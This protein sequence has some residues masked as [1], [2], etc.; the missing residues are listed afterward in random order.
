M[1]TYLTEYFMLRHACFINFYRIIAYIK[2]CC[3][4]LHLLIFRFILLQKS[5][6]NKR[7]FIIHITFEAMGSISGSHYILAR[8]LTEKHLFSFPFFLGGRLY[9]MC[10]LICLRYCLNH[11]LHSVIFLVKT[12]KRNKFVAIKTEGFHCLCC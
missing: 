11:L 4:K 9:I 2:T 3:L 6:V 10:H 7:G 5:I 8:N 12:I 1:A